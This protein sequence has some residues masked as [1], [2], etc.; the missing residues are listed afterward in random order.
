MGVFLSG[1]V[2]DSCHS[3]L[4]QNLRLTPVT[5]CSMGQD[6][7]SVILLLGRW[8]INNES[9]ATTSIALL[10]DALV[11]KYNRVTTVNLNKMSRDPDSLA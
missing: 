9:R 8:S 7:D 3:Q 1:C 11:P 4:C 2:T 6:P 10:S 5:L